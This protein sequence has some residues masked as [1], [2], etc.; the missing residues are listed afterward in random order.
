[1]GKKLS[2]TKWGNVSKFPKLGRYE[3]WPPPKMETSGET[4]YIKKIYV[5]IV[6]FKNKTLYCKKNIMMQKKCNKKM[7]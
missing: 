1:M 6:F 2:C 5:Y 7:Q 3:T 4:L